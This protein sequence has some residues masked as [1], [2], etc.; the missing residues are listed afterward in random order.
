VQL[1]DLNKGDLVKGKGDG[2]WM[3]DDYGIGIV[4]A[5][6]QLGSVKVYWPKQK[7]WSV[8]SVRNVRR[9]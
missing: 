8:T 6:D 4:L 1:N 9:A 2:R 5:S 3:F 7:F